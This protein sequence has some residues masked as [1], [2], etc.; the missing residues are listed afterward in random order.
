MS[1]SAKGDKGHPLASWSTFWGTTGDFQSVPPADFTKLIDPA[2]P[3]L[4]RLLLPTA[5]GFPRPP[6]GADLVKLGIVKKK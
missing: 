2:S 3:Q 4:E 6:P 5:A 1:A